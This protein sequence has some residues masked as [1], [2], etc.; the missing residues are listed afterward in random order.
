M[1]G[2]SDQTWLLYPTPWFGISLSLYASQT[3]FLT[4]QLLTLT[5]LLLNTTCPGLANSVDPDQ[6]VSSEASWSGSAL[7]AIKYVNLYQKSGSSYLIGW[8]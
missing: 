8:K 2:G 6:L 5:L 3:L 4:R 7:F 1:I